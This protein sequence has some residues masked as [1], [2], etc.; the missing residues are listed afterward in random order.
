MRATPGELLPCLAAVL[1]VLL[2]Y[3]LARRLH[4]WLTTTPLPPDPWA[5]MIPDAESLET[6]VCVNC[7]C[8]VD[9][10]R[11]HYCPRC[12]AV[13]GEYTR[14]LPFENIR[15]NYGIFGTLWRKLGDPGTPWP[16]QL[17]AMVLILAL[18]WPIALVYV[19]SLP[20]RWLGQFR[21]A[22]AGPSAA[23][24]DEDKQDDDDDGIGGDQGNQ[25]AEAAADVAGEQADV[26]GFARLRDAPEGVE[27]RQQQGQGDELDE[28]PE[29]RA[30]R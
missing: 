6:P 23:S 29:S 28:P 14:Y 27:I 3:A 19:I 24:P 25:G 15:F 4:R 13:V 26:P 7:Q 9:S 20:W 1:A 30:A 11:Q 8:P 21:K 10:P 22:A 16:T 12:G 2:A 5:G 18:A 17:L